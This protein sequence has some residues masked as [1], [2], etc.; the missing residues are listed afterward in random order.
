[1]PR[2]VGIDIPNDKRI[3]ISLTYVHGIGATSAASICEVLDIEPSKRAHD[4]TEDE[5]SR[6]AAYIKRTRRLPGWL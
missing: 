1:M 6:I 4:L 2:L 5:L 3:I